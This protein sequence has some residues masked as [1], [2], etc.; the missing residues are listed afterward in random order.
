MDGMVH[1][2]TKISNLILGTGVVLKDVNRFE[3]LRIFGR[4]ETALL[5]HLP[6]LSLTHQLQNF[7][8]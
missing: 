1:T 7:L 4:I 3:H 2:E 5:A 6:P 8:Q